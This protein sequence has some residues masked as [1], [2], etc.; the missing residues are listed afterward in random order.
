MQKQ[1]DSDR[2]ESNQE[3]EFFGNIAI[4]Y[5]SQT[6]IPPEIFYC[7]DSGPIYIE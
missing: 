2:M 7:K 1:Y 3:I 5:M 6:I 4:Q